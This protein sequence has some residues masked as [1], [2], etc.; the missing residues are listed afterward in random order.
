MVANA[1]R[2][3]DLRPG[4]DMVTDFLGLGRGSSG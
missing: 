3:F 4:V 1:Y 2:T